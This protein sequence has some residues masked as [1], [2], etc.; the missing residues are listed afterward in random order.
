MTDLSEYKPQGASSFPL[1]PEEFDADE[2]IS[3]AKL[4][5]KFILVQ[6]DGSEF[7][8][9]DALK[10]WI[11]ILDE[12]LLEQQRRAYAVT[13]VDEEETVESLRKKRKKVYVNGEDVS[14]EFSIFGSL[15]GACLA[16]LD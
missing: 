6:S 15:P 14:V 11:P 8:F 10:R 9:D 13:G 7:E 16:Y 5:R 12:A 4:D 2:R 3:F 1:N